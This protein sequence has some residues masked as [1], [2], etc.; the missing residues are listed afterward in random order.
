MPKIYNYYLLDRMVLLHAKGYEDMYNKSYRNM[1]E[2]FIAKMV[3]KYIL[4]KG[5]NNIGIVS[6]YSA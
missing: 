2:V 5:I 3:Y 4:D 6:P 1:A